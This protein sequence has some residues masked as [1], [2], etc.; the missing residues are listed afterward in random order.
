MIKQ[1]TDTADQLEQ[2]R[3]ELATFEQLKISE[4]AAIPRRL[5]NITADVKKQ[6]DREKELQSQFKE[7]MGKLEEARLGRFQQE[8]VDKVPMDT[9]I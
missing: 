7:V 2:S 8:N 6:T 5:A 4:T 1:L 3:L 9:D